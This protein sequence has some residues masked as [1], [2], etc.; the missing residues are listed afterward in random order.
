MPKLKR[1]AAGPRVEERLLLDGIALQA[2]RVA[3]RRVEPSVAVE[4]DLADADRALGDAA[5][6]TAGHAADPPAGQRL[7]QIGDSGF[8]GERVEQGRHATSATPDPRRGIT[9]W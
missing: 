4:P 3:P 2:G 5:G 8:R 6:V 7:V 9:G 1:Q